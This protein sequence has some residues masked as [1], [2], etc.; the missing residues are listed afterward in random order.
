MNLLEFYIN[1]L[2]VLEMCVCVRQCIQTHVYTP[3]LSSY[4]ELFYIPV[5]S[6][7]YVSQVN[8]ASWRRQEGKGVCRLSVLV[9]TLYWDTLPIYWPSS[10]PCNEHVKW[11]SEQRLPL[12]PQNTCGD[13]L[14]HGDNWVVAYAHP[15]NGGGMGALARLA[16]RNYLCSEHLFNLRI[17]F[18]YAYLKI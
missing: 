16:E 2:Y 12:W 7:I 3:I 1:H 18:A 6:G 11:W 4:I 15:P 8:N 5:I 13:L 9:C 10:T 14:T 17:W